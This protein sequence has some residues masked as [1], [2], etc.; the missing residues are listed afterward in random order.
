VAQ[1]RGRPADAAPAYA[2]LIQ[3]D[4]RRGDAAQAIDR[5]DE[6][7]EAVPAAAL[8][9][10]SLVKLAGILA[11]RNES[12]RAADALRR[13]LLA[14]GTQP[15][16][17]LAVKLAEIAA[18]REPRVARAAARVALSRP[19]ID[20]EARRRVEAILAKVGSPGGITEVAAEAQANAGPPRRG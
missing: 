13:A 5:W 3:A 8:D 4:L 7:R 1:S 9:A 14:L 19:G 18:D 12:T 10:K 2:R 17:V 16:P 15:D 11:D 20:P 6:L